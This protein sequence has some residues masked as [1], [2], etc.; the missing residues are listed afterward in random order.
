MGHTQTD[1]VKVL[2]VHKST[3]GRELLRKRG[4]R[5]Y[6]PKQAHQ[7]ALERCQQKSKTAIIAKT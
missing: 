4:N 2:E 5:G 6:R 1:I 7:K 3:I